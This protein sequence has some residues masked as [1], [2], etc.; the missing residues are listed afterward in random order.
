MRSCRRTASRDRAMLPSES[1]LGKN[2]AIRGFV[3]R[4][5]GLP[6]GPWHRRP[7]A[8]L[9]SRTISI[10][11]NELHGHFGQTN[12]APYRPVPAYLAAPPRTVST[13]LRAASTISASSRVRQSGGAKPR[14]SPCGMARPMTPRSAS[15]V[16]TCGP[17]LLRGVEEHAVVPVGD[18]LDRRQHAV[19]A[20]VAD[21]PVAADGFRELGAE[22]GAGLAGIGRPGPSRRSVRDWRRRPQRRSDA[23]NRSSHGRCE[24][25]LSEPCTSTCQILSRDDDAGQ[26]RI[27]RGQAL[28]DGDQVRLDAVVVGAEH[29]C[30]AG[31][32]R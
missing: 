10:W 1:K 23:P 6:I 32:S 14:M 25:S 11:P 20:H 7:V 12:L 2:E 18:E 30:R 4:G 5:R 15:A 31:R 24:P 26:R 28:G 8:S 9:R 16:A 22:I 21:M 19:A 27:G 29:R 13:A 3:T 17:D